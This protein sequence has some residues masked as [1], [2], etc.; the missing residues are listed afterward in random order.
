M[1]VLY[2]TEYANSGREL[3]K[4]IVQSAE[5]PRLAGQTIAI[6]AGSVQSANL[7]AKTRLIRVHTDAICSVAI[8]A[9]PTAVATDM[10]LAAN[11]TEY[12][13]LTPELVKAGCKVAVITNT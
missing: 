6:G 13:A 10:R 5:E 3:K 7:N 1:A 8:G 9:N 11:Q 12:I 4:N 2:I